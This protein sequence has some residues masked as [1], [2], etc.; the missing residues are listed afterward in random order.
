MIG[1]IAALLRTQCMTSG[2]LLPILIAALVIAVGC[3]SAPSSPT[4]AKPSVPTTSAP[5][6]SIVQ[7]AA[8]LSLTVDRFTADVNATLQEMDRVLASAATDLG[9]TGIGGPEA[10]AT[11][12]RIAASSPHSADIITITPEGQIAAAMPPEYA[13]IVGLRIANL[14]HVRTGLQERRPLMSMPFSAVEGFD[15]VAIQRPVTD[16]T[17]AFLGLVSVA[18]SPQRLLAESADRALAGSNFTAWAMDTDGRLIYD[19]DHGDLVVRNM[20]TDPVFTDWP[21]LAAF[22]KRMVVAPVGDGW[23]IFTTTRSELP[24]KMAEWRTAGLHRTEWRLV[25]AEGYEI[26]PQ[27]A[28]ESRIT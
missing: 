27:Y 23:Y 4:N 10:N 14:T 2:R 9:R 11:L 6:M 25:V 5:T 3:T 18:F 15:A 21:V 12:A 13:G 20:I 19:R 17:G 28:I 22:T 24:G 7:P 16:G 8:N 1:F 26:E